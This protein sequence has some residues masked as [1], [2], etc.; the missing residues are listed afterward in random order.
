MSGEVSGRARYPVPGKVDIG[1]EQANG[2]AGN[3]AQRVG[4]LCRPHGADDDVRLVP[5]QRTGW[6]LDSS[7]SKSAG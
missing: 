5:C 1:S 6:T 7:S 3:S 4:A 2:D